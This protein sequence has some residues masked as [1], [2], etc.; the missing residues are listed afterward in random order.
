M[1]RNLNTSIPILTLRE[2]P[3]IVLAIGTWYIFVLLCNSFVSK[4]TIW[5]SISLCLPFSVA[6]S[7]CFLLSTVR[8]I[9]LSTG[10]QLS[11]TELS[12]SLLL[13]YRTVSL[14]HVIAVHFR[15]YFHFICG[16]VTF[17]GGRYSLYLRHLTS[18]NATDN[19]WAVY[20]NCIEHVG[21]Q[22]VSN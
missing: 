18:H 17:I 3:H 10:C 12:W 6:P 20:F 7:N 21:L 2:Q 22:Q 15:L 5:L 1:S 14:H 11:I 9:R 16:N 4:E 19:Y 8:C 13:A